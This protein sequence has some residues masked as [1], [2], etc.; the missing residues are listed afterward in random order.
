MYAD[1][2]VYQIKAL[3]L[4]FSCDLLLS[5]LIAPLDLLNEPGIMILD[6]ALLKNNGR[7][8]M[9]TRKGVVLR[10]PFSTILVV[11][12]LRAGITASPALRSVSLVASLL[13]IL[14]LCILNLR[15]IEHPD[16][17]ILV[18]VLGCALRIGKVLVGLADV[19]FGW[20][21]KVSCVDHGPEDAIIQLVSY[22]FAVFETQVVCDESGRYSHDLD[23]LVL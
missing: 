5:D 1:V 17:V 13:S 23:Q 14:R 7:H 9:L 6:I 20:K 22:L 12:V 15:N 8:F 10:G 4:I 3:H 2:V 19:F 11:L 21:S 18:I 16:P